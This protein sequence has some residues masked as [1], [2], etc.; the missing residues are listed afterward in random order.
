MR[1]AACVFRESAGTFRKLSVRR[2]ISPVRQLGGNLAKPFSLP[3]G[4]GRRREKRIHFSGPTPRRTAPCLLRGQADEEMQSRRCRR[5]QALPNSA[6]LEL[7]EPARRRQRRNRTNGAS[8][9]RGGPFTEETGNVGIG[10]HSDALEENLGGRD[11]RR[12][13][14][15]LAAYGLRA[16]ATPREFD[17]LPAFRVSPAE[18][19][20]ERRRAGAFRRQREAGDHGPHYVRAEQVKTKRGR[21]KAE[22]A[23]CF[24]SPRP[25]AFRL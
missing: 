16:H 10:G 12:R 3:L 6:A 19:R 18:L 22:R 4:D 15:D 17:R 7:S 11:A 9:R 5:R 1:P 8:S 23:G 24:F 20:G 2:A 14:H 21:M 25:S 13:F